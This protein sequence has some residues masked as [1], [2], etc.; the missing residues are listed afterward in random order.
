MSLLTVLNVIVSCS[1]SARTDFFCY[2]E[3]E[4]IIEMVLLFLFVTHINHEFGSNVLGSNYSVPL[5]FTNCSLEN[6]RFKYHLIFT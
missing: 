3:N 1:D 2:I 6:F 4:Y 5:K